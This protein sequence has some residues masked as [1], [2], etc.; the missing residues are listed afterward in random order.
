MLSLTAFEVGLFGWMALMQLVFVPGP[1]LHPDHAAYWFLMQI[2]MI[3][4][5]FTA[6]P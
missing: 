2:G 1:H 4:G 6:W 5:F 3:V